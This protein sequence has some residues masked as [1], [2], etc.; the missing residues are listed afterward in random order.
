[1]YHHQFGSTLGKVGIC[2][3]AEQAGRTI[4][5]K[6]TVIFKNVE[7]STHL[8]ENEYS[9]TFLFERLEEFVQD[10]HLSRVIDEMFVSGVGWA[11]FLIE[12]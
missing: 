9:G 12:L 6:E 5:S 11:R 10:N 1:V 4:L 3:L 2:K 8:A 7:N